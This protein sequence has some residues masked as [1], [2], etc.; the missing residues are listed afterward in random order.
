MTTRK[1][2]ILFL[3][4]FLTTLIPGQNN[5]VPN[6]SFEIYITCPN[7]Q[8]QIS[9]AIDW[10]KPTKGPSDYYNICSLYFGIPFNIGGFQRGFNN[11]YG[12]AGLVG[13]GSIDW[14]TDDTITYRQYIQAK[15]D[16]P[17]IAGKTYYVT[18]F[19]A[20]ADSS[21]TAGDGMGAYFSQGQVSLSG[22]TWAAFGNLSYTPQISNPDSNILNNDLNW[23]K[24]SGSFVAAGGEDYVTIGNFKNNASTKILQRV[25]NN[26]Y[27]GNYAYYYIDQV[28]VSMS[29]ATCAENAV[30]GLTTYNSNTFSYYYNSHSDKIV[31]KDALEHYEVTVTDLCGKT[32]KQ[33]LLE[34][35]NEI[36]VSELEAGCYL[37]TVSGRYSKTSKKIIIE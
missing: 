11:G 12:Y 7:N 16:S 15:L 28:C 17:M 22:S 30:L 8:G 32:V 31:F 6:P 1:I 2:L 3:V 20:L 10:Y 29:A 37:V 24:I 36:D 35:S 5:L 13:Y 25:P 26:P 34:S 33:S 4:V 19:V 21:T 27:Y 9:Y 23:T 14:D 18:F